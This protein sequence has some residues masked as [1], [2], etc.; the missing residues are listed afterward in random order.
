MRLKYTRIVVLVTA[1]LESLQG[2]HLRWRIIIITLQCIFF[3]QFSLFD[4]GVHSSSN[5]RW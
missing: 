3:V 1:Y 2:L 4:A 5:R